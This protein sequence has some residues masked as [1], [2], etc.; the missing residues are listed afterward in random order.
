[1]NLS[2]AIRY[3]AYPA[4]IC[5]LQTCY[6]YS[7]VQRRILAHVVKQG[8]RLCLVDD[9]LWQQIPPWYIVSV[10]SIDLRADG[11]YYARHTLDDTASYHSLDGCYQWLRRR[12]IDT[13]SGWHATA[14][15]E[16][17]IDLGAR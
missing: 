7:T 13:Q 6:P 12:K 11:L 8:G 1:M 10:T 9:R 15:A 14:N 3:G 17:W 2:Q 5:C 4:A 16:R